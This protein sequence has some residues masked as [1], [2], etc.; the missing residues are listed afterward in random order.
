VETV[1]VLRHGGVGEIRLDRPEVLNAMGVPFPDEMAAA[2]RELAADPTV[3][4]VVV[5]GA[6]RAFSSGLD[7]DDLAAGRIDRDW[8]IRAEHVMRALETMAV[9]VIAGVQGWC[10]GGGVQLAIAC[11]VRIAAGDA[12]FALPAAK[13]AF[14]PGMGTW[15]L[16]RLIGMGHAR[17]LVLSGESIDAAEAARIGLVNKVV[18]RADLEAEVFAWAERY[19]EVPAPSLASAKRLSNLAYDLPFA[20]FVDV[21][22]EEMAAVLSTEEHLAARRAWATRQKRA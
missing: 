21:I 7:L 17:H 3:R 9:A 18:P 10:L 2:I 22:G 19:A 15:R 8:F 14:L 11:D 12:M 1:A 6:G 5:T 20:S 13:E 16:P 4:V